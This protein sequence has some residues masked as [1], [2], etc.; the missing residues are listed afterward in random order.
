MPWYWTATRSIALRSSVEY[1][2][3]ILLLITEFNIVK[4]R[5]HKEFTGARLLRA[6]TAGQ[7]RAR[8]LGELRLLGIIRYVAWHQG[9]VKHKYL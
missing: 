5:M 1:S 6:R 7:W 3:D 8:L 2:S 4:K 9:D